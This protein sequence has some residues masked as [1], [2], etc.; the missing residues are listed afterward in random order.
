MLDDRQQINFVRDW[1]RT[2]DPSL[3]RRAKLD[4]GF[5][6]REHVLQINQ[7]KRNESRMERGE[8]IAGV[9]KAATMRTKE[10][11]ETMASALTSIKEGIA[12][13]TGWDAFVR[14]IGQKVLGE[15]DAEKGGQPVSMETRENF[16][17][18]ANRQGSRDDGTM[19]GRPFVQGEYG[20]GGLR[21]AV[22]SSTANKGNPEDIKRN[23]KESEK[24]YWQKIAEMHNKK[25]AERKKAKG[26]ISFDM[27]TED[28]SLPWTP[29]PAAGIN[30]A[31]LVTYHGDESKPQPAVSPAQYEENK[32]TRENPT[33]K[34][35]KEFKEKMRKKSPVIGAALNKAEEFG[36]KKK[37]ETEAEEPETTTEIDGTIPVRQSRSV[38]SNITVNVLDSLQLMTLFEHSWEKIRQLLQRQQSELALLEYQA[39][40]RW[41]GL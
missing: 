5:A 13:I 15:G 19:K 30:Y 21:P 1:S 32:R 38:A 6:E 26:P 24:D 10:I 40:L 39:N 22:Y 33:P 9:G 7:Y 35:D 2:M 36:E 14:K 34:S 27:R 28:A 29:T 37:A 3:E 12:F 4:R 31:A 23:P 41:E 25:T 20:A 18:D 11:F 16:Y 8:I 17:S